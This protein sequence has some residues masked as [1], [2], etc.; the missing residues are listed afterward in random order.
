MA[1]ASSAHQQSLR[2]RACR[3]L[4]I[5]G[6]A[7][8]ILTACAPAEEPSG[9]ARSAEI[10]AT[11]GDALAPVDAGTAG[12]FFGG[13][14]ELAGD[15][16]YVGAPFAPLPAGRGAVQPY[17]RGE[18]GW[19]P[20]PLLSA[21]DGEDGD[22]FGESIALSGDTLIVGAPGKSGGV[23]A[24]YVFVRDGDGW[25]EQAKLLPSNAGP[26]ALFGRHV[27]LSG[28]LAVVS[29]HR[30]DEFGVYSGSVRVFRRTLGTWS[31]TDVLY[32]PSHAS[33]T[34]FGVSLAFSENL[35]LVGASSAGPA[36][37]GEVH[38]FSWNGSEWVLVYTFLEPGDAEDAFGRSV[39]V[40]GD[41]VLIG[42]AHSGAAHKGAVFVYSAMGGAWPL[43]ATLTDDAV[44]SEG[45][46]GVDV[47]LSGGL[48]VVGAS[49]DAAAGLAAGALYAFRRNKG[50]WGAPIRLTSSLS[51]GGD[52]LG[53]AVA[54]QG[55]EVLG[56]APK[57]DSPYADAGAVYTFH[58]V[59][60]T[61]DSCSEGG[62]CA[63]GFCV[64]GVCCDKPCQEPGLAC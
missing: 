14:I 42:A 26:D 30:D 48:A 32:P 1:K 2:E 11:E 61:G 4:Q 40:G 34:F 47:A 35:L 46:F 57:A 50:E 54:A 31:E 8:A 15:E 37:Q 18:P 13:A 52:W 56:G 63:T 45:G 7:T 41:T 49:G 44:T 53:Y 28:D 5:A 27:R 59:A 62:E 29:A 36:A 3:P 55:P 12:G 6:L 10:S 64:D 25:V 60:D 22:R 58:V 19:I 33:G 9:T 24:A 16:L 23:G 43:E 38:A 39:A 17:V 51:T 20:G 21:S